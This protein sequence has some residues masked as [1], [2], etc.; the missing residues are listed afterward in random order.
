MSYLH[1][2]VLTFALLCLLLIGLACAGYAKTN[3]P[4]TSE[5]YAQAGDKYLERASKAGFAPQIT[6]NANRAIA[7][8]LKAIYLEEK[9]QTE[10]L[11]QI[12]ENVG[13]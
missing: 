10:I 5:Y 6:A 4:I 11:R 2:R 9:K 12:K 8:Y 1:K 3:T 13:R 7:C